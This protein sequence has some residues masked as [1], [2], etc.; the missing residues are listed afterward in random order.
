[1]VKLVVRAVL[2]VVEQQADLV[3]AVKVV[4]KLVVASWEAKEGYLGAVDEAEGDHMEVVMV[5]E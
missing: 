5:V 2:E 4:A 1:M 3:V